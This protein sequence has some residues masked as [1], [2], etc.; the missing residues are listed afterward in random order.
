MRIG[1]GAL[2]AI[3]SAS[4]DRWRHCVAQFVAHVNPVRVSLTKVPW[5]CTSMN[6][7]R[8]SCQTDPGRFGNSDGVLEARSHEWWTVVLEDVEDVEMLMMKCVNI[9]GSYT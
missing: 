4:L 2:F 3:A 8:H 6:A 1:R 7:S 5:S 9:F